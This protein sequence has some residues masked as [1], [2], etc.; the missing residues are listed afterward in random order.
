MSLE[1]KIVA[2]KQAYQ[3]AK[4]Q[5]PTGTK[6]IVFLSDIRKLGCRERRAF[7]DA[8]ESLIENVGDWVYTFTLFG[9]TGFYSHCAINPYTITD[10]GL[11]SIFGN[12]LGNPE[13]LN[14][15]Y[16]R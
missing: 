16:Y 8:I 12:L 14:I 3:D 13:K 7:D 4:E 15:E 11:E 6:A 5:M 1:E 9:Q 2:F 10:T